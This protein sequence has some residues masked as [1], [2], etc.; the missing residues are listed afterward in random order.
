MLR[1]ITRTIAFVVLLV[2][3]SLLVWC[4]IPREPT[5]Q[6]KKLSEYL[7]AFAKDGAQVH[8]QPPFELVCSFQPSPERSRAWEALP[9]FGTNALPLMIE[10]LQ[11]KDSRLKDLWI[12]WTRK[13]SIVSFTPLRAYEKR[14]A[15]LAGFIR[16]GRQAEAALPS[17]IPLLSDPSLSREAVFALT[18]I[19]P[20]QA[21]DI[22]ALTNALIDPGTWNEFEAMAAL[23]SFGEKAAGAVPILIDKLHSTNAG[24][25]AVAA[26]ALARIRK[27]PEEAVS[28]ILRNLQSTN[29][30]DGYPDSSIRMNLWALGE[31]GHYADVALPAISNF[32]NDAD[33]QISDAARAAIQRITSQPADRRLP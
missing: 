19:R 6:G 2:I 13:Q 10:W 14:M 20:E 21:Q 4:F 29:Q 17:I 24:A 11:A 8:N 12:R 30:S 3:V 1:R 7:R 28:I 22:L 5:Y 32:V 16:F 18:F 31:F 26:V 25:R 27:R 33:R 23:G 15:A 9:K